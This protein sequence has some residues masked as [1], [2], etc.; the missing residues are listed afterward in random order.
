MAEIRDYDAVQ[1]EIKATITDAV[2]AALT[3][4]TRY[5][6]QVVHWFDSNP[7]ATGGD[8]S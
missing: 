1:A 3:T 7:D 4:N 2:N 8:G 5:Q 6:T